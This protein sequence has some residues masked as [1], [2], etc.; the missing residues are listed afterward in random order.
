MNKNIVALNNGK[1]HQP[2]LKVRTYEPKGNKFNVGS[3]GN[4]KDTNMLKRPKGRTFSL[5]FMQ[6]Q[7]EI[8]RMKRSL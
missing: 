7:M 3:S 6:T 8:G 4:K 2:I 1:G 5:Q